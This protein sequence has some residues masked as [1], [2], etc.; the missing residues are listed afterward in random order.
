MSLMSDGDLCSGVR[1]L[2]KLKNFGTDDFGVMKQ[3]SD[4]ASLTS[5]RI[6]FLCGEFS[7]TFSILKFMFFMASNG[8]NLFLAGSSSISILDSCG[9]IFTGVLVNNGD[10]TREGAGSFH[11]PWFSRLNAWDFSLIGLGSIKDHK[12]DLGLLLSS[13][14]SDVSMRDNGLGGGRDLTF[15]LG[16]FLVSNF[17]EN[18]EK[19]FLTGERLTVSTY[20]N[21]FNSGDKSNLEVSCVKDGL[22]ADRLDWVSSV[23][24]LGCFSWCVNDWLESLNCDAFNEE[25]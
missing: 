7:S 9:G 4:K 13:S 20:L 15:S 8:L 17:V 11:A 6:S 2:F 22:D 5:A 21:G 3:L 14:S 25:H 10:R 19:G 18:G 16:L 12:L 23:L 1:V 24:C